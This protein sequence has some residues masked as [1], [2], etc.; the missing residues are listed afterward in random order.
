MAAEGEKEVICCHGEVDEG[1][2]GPRDIPRD[3][4]MSSVKQ[5][6]CS[7]DSDTSF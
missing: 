2:I 5:N 6:T 4:V 3:G 1:F 7:S